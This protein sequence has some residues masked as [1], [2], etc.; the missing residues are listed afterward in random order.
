MHKRINLLDPEIR[1]NP[2]PVYAELRRSRPVCQVD[3]GGIWAVTR[4]ADVQRVLR[5][6]ERFPS[7]G[8]KHIFCPPWLGHQPLGDSLIAKDPP[9]HTKLRALV[10]RAFTPRSIARLESRVTA[11]AAELADRIRSMGEADFMAELAE[12]LPARVIAEILGLDPALHREFKRWGA[13]LANVTPAEPE[14]ALASAIRGTIREMQ[15]YLD[16]VIAARRRA[17]REDLVS[18]LLR[19]EIDGQALSHAELMGMLFIILPAG[20]ETT[21]NLLANA[22]LRLLDAPGDLARLHADR[23]RIPAFIE[24]VLR[25]DPP[26]HAVGRM[27]AADVEIGGVTVPA[28]AAV[29]ALV[30]SSNRDEA[31]FPD[32]DRFDMD[33]ESQGGH[34]FGY[35]IHFCLGATLARIEGRVALEALLARFRGFERIPAELTYSNAL[36]VRGP[37]SLPV[38][39]LPA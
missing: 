21:T 36:T 39:F 18:E 17:P 1:K 7:S 38:R 8:F 33:R 23:A 32:P 6:P 15:G 37:L 25:H 27:A 26:V 24:E 22:M 3:P 11:L 19:A 31:A 20:F 2:Y 5:D 4:H 16:D 14:P 12:P 10:S 30:G 13:H 9:E 28:G 35:G 29:L 34:A